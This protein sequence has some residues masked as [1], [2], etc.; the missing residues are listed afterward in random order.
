MAMG[1]LLPLPW[2]VINKSKP[3]IVAENWVRRWQ[4]IPQQRIT[5]RDMQRIQ[6]SPWANEIAPAY[7]IQEGQY[8]LRQALS[9]AQKARLTSLLLDSVQL[10]PR[11]SAWQMTREENYFQNKLSRLE[12]Y[13]AIKAR[14]LSKGYT[15][16]GMAWGYDGMEYPWWAMMPGCELVDV[17]YDSALRRL[18]KE[19]WV[20]GVISEGPNLGPGWPKYRVERI[21]EMYWMDFG[22]AVRVP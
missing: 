13:Q 20:Q 5:M 8:V 14:C 12:A 18:A 10:A 11:R 21:G 1:L 7:E 15:K 9:Q 16:I 4:G 22:K 6:R 19:K 2:L 3:L 17:H